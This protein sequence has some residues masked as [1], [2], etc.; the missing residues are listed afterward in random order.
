MVPNA[1]VA[2]DANS[3]ES[4]RKRRVRDLARHLC[5]RCWGDPDTICF[6]VALNIGPGRSFVVP[7]KI[8]QLPAW[9]FYVAAAEAVIDADV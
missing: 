6:D 4:H 5:R 3:D 1:V 7:D 2:E 8:Y 9:S